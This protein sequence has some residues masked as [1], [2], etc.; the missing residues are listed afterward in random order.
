MEPGRTGQDVRPGFLPSIRQDFILTERNENS[1]ADFKTT[2]F[3][4][5]DFALCFLHARLATL[6]GF[7]A[8]AR[9]D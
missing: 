4:N 2:H 9:D 5:R 3:V 6:I 1:D 7:E 8:R